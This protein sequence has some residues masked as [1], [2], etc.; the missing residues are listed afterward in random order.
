MAEAR[1]RLR[2]LE[3][4]VTWLEQAVQ[5]LRGS[6]RAAPAREKTDELSERER[7]LAEHQA[8]ACFA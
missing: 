3:T 6:E 1:V 8:V 2:K 4:W 7:L 5:K